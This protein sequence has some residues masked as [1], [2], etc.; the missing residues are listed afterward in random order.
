MRVSKSSL[1]GAFLSAALLTAC[2]GATDAPLRP[3]P[4]KVTAERTNVR[5]AYGVL[6]SFKDGSGDGE[7]PMAGLLNV[8]GTL[9]GTTEYGGDNGDGT[10]FLIT[11]AGTETVLHSF[12]R[13]KGSHPQAGLINVGGTLYGTTAEGGSGLCRN[14][15]NRVVGCGTVFSMTMSG[16]ETVLRS[17]AGGSGD[18]AYPY[19]GL[20]NVNGTLYGTTSSGGTTNEGTV[21][22]I[23]T[24]GAETVLHSFGTGSGDGAYPYAGLINFKGTLYSTTNEGG[25]NCGASGGCGTVF[26]ITTDGVE[27]VLY[28][29][30]G[31]PD[32]EHPFAGLINVN[33]TLYGT[34]LAGGTYCESSSAIGCGT[35]FA[36]TT[37][38]AET[39]LHSFGIGSG[40]GTYPDA[41]LLNVKDT[42][43]GTTDSGG[44]YVYDGTVFKITTAGVESVVHSFKGDPDG[45]L[46]FAGLINVNGTLYGTTGY[47][48]S[49]SCDIGCGTVFSLSP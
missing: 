45:G 28:S 6:Y 26:K 14:R 11:T 27:S 29:F 8:K 36:I 41:G 24:S 20:I 7:E 4:A 1:V 38:G 49:G 15:V 47:G 19:A 3:S 40:D 18:G 16:V 22:G 21:F 5:P 17:F 10:V 44:A 42:L 25:A 43:Y 13:K 46:P 48:G 33:G 2:D 32:G 39:V 9:Y 34:T 37:Y 31:D 35:V 30:K 12:N 23:T